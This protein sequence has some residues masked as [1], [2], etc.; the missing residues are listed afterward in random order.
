MDV[1]TYDTCS[2]EK[3]HEYQVCF[4]FS[5]HVADVDRNQARTT[6]G[7]IPWNYEDVDLKRNSQVAKDPIPGTE[8]VKAFILS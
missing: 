4:Q 2:S 1:Y 7:Q 3:F 6:E 8:R 5:E